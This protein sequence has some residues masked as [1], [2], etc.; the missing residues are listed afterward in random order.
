MISDEA[1]NS[2]LRALR[3]PIE[4]FAYSTSLYSCCWFGIY[5]D[6]TGH[7][8]ASSGD[9]WQ[10]KG[11][12]NWIAFS[13][14]EGFLILLY[15]KIQV[16]IHQSCLKVVLEKPALKVLGDDPKLLVYSQAVVDFSL[17]ETV[18][19]LVCESTAKDKICQVLP[20][21]VNCNCTFVMD[22]DSVSIAD[23][24]ADDLGSRCSNGTCR[25]YFKLLKRKKISF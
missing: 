13:L 4:A 6:I 3:S 20:L 5:G 9:E 10:K 1:L 8:D 23:M 22:L 15:L 25:S 12:G 14:D 18:D 16:L 11:N 2:G 17:S 19:I 7:S 24:K 21:G